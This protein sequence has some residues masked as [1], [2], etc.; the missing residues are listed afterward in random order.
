MQTHN[1]KAFGDALSYRVAGQNFIVSRQIFLTS[2]G[3]L[4]LSSKCISWVIFC[5]VQVNLPRAIIYSS[6]VQLHVQVVI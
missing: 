4:K 3:D 2:V 5:P 1:L 6:L